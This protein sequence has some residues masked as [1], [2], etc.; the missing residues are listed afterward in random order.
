MKTR[1]PFARFGALALAATLSLTTLTAC[2]D[3]K[4]SPN[5]SKPTGQTSQSPQGTK[6]LSDE[7]ILAKIA[8]V[9]S[10]DKLRPMTMD[11]TMTISMSMLGQTMDMDMDWTLEQT[12]D[13]IHMTMSADMMG[14]G[15]MDTEAWGEA[16]ADGTWTVYVN[17]NDSWAKEEMSVEEANEMTNPSSSQ[18]NMDELIDL[19]GEDNFTVERNSDSYTLT[20]DV[21]QDKMNELSEDLLAEQGMTSGEVDFEEYT[22]FVTYDAD[23]FYATD[24]EIFMKYSATAEGITVP[25]TVTM[26]GTIDNDPSGLNIEV[27]AEAKSATA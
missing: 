8:E 21:P 14:M 2:G 15:A 7:E 6:N 3:E 4:T 10:S 9:N 22:I 24:F 5:N 27:P 13:A 12:S 25:A 11:A 23:T 1:K 19:L 18:L 17:A 26:T 20:V 16:N